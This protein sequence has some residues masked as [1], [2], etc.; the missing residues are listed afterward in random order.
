MPKLRPGS[1]RSGNKIKFH[2]TVKLATGLIINSTVNGPAIEMTL[3]QGQAVPGL[4]K[5]LRGM[6]P[7]YGPRKPE[8]MFPILKS[9]LPP[10]EYVLGEAL[11]L[12]QSN[13]SFIK[14]IVRCVDTHFIVVDVNHRLAGHDLVYDLQLVDILA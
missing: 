11:D 12:Q 4:E 9:A 6:L 1:A 2:Y 7:A 5:A 14:G 3:G 10:R 13:G 8:L